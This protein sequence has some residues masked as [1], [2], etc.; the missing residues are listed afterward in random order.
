[1]T[2]AATVI[3][4]SY[5]GA[6]RLRRTLDSLTTQDFPADQ[7]ELIA[8]DNNST[9]DTLAILES[10]RDKLPIKPFRHPVPGKSGALNK[11]LDLA[12]GDLVIFT[13]D[14]IEADPNWLGKMVACATANPEFGIFGGRIVPDWERAPNGQPFLDWIPMGSTFAVVDDAESG[15]CD[16]TKVWGPNTAIRRQHL[17]RDGRYREDIG[18]LPGGLFAMGEDSEI[19]LRLAR[20]GVKTY[21]C[22]DAMVHHFV[23]A[24]SMT[25]RWVQ[26]R[27]E[28]LGYGMPAV[29]PGEVPPGPRLRGVPLNTWVESASWAIRSAVLYPLPSNRLRF[30]AIWK[31][32]YMRGY[33]A[34]VRRYVPAGQG[35]AK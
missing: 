10:Y 7:W 35:A 13:D 25:E 34:G 17:D 23:P 15:P 4:S 33:R 3:F 22:G 29:F 11:A 2:V 19:V 27:A 12:Q 8:V 14:D 24:S 30:W 26:M 28:R 9:D 20:R 18:P 21:R 6:K 1:M 31:H 5:N 16:P 32:N